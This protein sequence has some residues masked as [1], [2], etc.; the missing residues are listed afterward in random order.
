MAQDYTSIS[1]RTNT[2][3]N[4]K[5]LE[6]AKYQTCIGVFAT[7]KPLPQNKA[8]NVT[9]RRS[10]QWPTLETAPLTEGTT[11]AS[12]DHVYE[13]VAV[14]MKQFGDVGEITDVVD[15]LCEDP[16]LNDIVM[17]QGDQA[18]GTTDKETFNT[19][20]ASTN[21]IYAGGV[22]GR[23][24]IIDVLDANSLDLAYR[25][26]RANRGLFINKRLSPSPNYNT[27]GIRASYLAFGH[28][29]LQSDLEAISGYRSTSEYGTETVVHEWEVGSFKNIRFCLSP[30]YD[31]YA[32]AGG[33]A[34]TNGLVSTT[35]TNADVYPLVILARDGLGAVP[36]AGKGSMEV[37]IINSSVKTKSDILGQRGFAGWKCYYASVRLNEA[38][39]LVIETGASAL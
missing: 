26:L 13:D 27:W 10:A 17:M 37:S 6:H 19:A 15:D 32:D 36:L 39:C 29:D 33:L 4:A 11:P 1:Q 22:A 24:N 7:T 2:Y 23:A 14:T 21:V 5:A 3:A 25:T 8:N 16:V 28:T 9:F 20:K 34:A 30:E 35:G 18:G 12:R 38:W 31:A